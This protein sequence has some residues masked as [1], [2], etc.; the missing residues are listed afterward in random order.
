MYHPLKNVP[1]LCI[2]KLKQSDEKNLV[3]FLCGHK[4]VRGLWKNE[5]MCP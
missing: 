3:N 1:G 2:L 5:S 4:V